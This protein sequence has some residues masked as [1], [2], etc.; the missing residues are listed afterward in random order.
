[1]GIAE[2]IT[3]ILALIKLFGETNM[4]WFIV[5]LPMILVYGIVV[6]I[7]LVIFI[8]ALFLKVRR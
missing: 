8:I 7:Y 4:S 5:F 6:T 1:M 3:L 2:V